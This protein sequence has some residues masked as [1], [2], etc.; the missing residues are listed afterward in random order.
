[1]SIASTPNKDYIATRKAVREQLK[2]VAASGD[3]DIESPAFK[4]L[5]KGFTL[6]LFERI[7]DDP[8]TYK[9]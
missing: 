7:L 4:A 6:N 1:M 3:Y 2:Q 9:I 5:F 8:E